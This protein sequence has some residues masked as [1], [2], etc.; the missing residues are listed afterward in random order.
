MIV[1]KELE[2]VTRELGISAH[3]L[4]SVSNNLSAHYKKVA[5]KKRDGGI[6]NL[7]VPDECLKHIQRRINEV[8][9]TQMTVS[10]YATA[11]KYGASLRSNAS[12]H[13]GKNKVLKL[14]IT[15]FF[16]SILYS[17]VKEY[18]FPEWKYSEEIR[19]LLSI[20][21]YF[22]ER[23]PQGA[24]TSPMVSNIIMYNFDEELG[25]WC[26]ER[27]IAY[28][29]YCDDMTFSGDFDENDVIKKVSPELK[30]YGFFI[31]SKKTG[32]YKKGSRQTVTG[33]VVNDG[34]SV[35]SEY[36][37]QIRKEVYYIKRFG[38]DAHLKRTGAEVNA[39]Q[40][41]RSLLGRI[42]YVLSVNSF[43]REMM[44]CRDQI[45]T[46]LKERTL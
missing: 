36:R 37:R 34:L 27:G 23:L 13:I 45:R 28:T 22:A 15:G 18:A 5:I 17:Q 35:P 32:C 42:S 16:D 24:P 12:P 40:Y 43:D 44:S 20:L 3:M 2:T 38:L 33:I 9:L 41:L 4:Y 7:R 11:Y 19:V 1:Y 46:L 25:A 14:D 8:F 39:E 26:E 6:R 21:C 10:R 31:N 29:R 30:K